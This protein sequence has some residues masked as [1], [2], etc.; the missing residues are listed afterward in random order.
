MTAAGRCSR[1]LLF[2]LLEERRVDLECLP[3]SQSKLQLLK[4]GCELLTIDQLNRRRSIS[5]ASLRASDVK[6]PVVMMIPLSAR[7]VIAPRKSRTWLG[8]TVTSLGRRTPTRPISDPAP[9]GWFPGPPCCARS[10]SRLPTFPVPS[11]RSSGREPRRASGLAGFRENPVCRI[12]QAPP[13]REVLDW[14]CPCRK[15]IAAH[16]PRSGSKSPTGCY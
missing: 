10:G 5:K 9:G 8:V 1:P 7:P 14:E 13:R 3:W 6:N 2:V 16:T 15:P 12:D 11:G 4:H